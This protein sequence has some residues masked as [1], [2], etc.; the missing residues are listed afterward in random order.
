MSGADL[1]ADET[2][3][4]VGT[5]GGL[6][7][8]A[9]AGRPGPPGW[10]PDADDA[11]VA[12]DDRHLLDYFTA[13]VLPAITPRQRE[14]LVRAAPLERLSGCA[15]RRR[16]AGH[17]LGRR[18]W[19][20]SIGPTCSWSRS[21][22]TTSGTGATICSATCC[23][24]NRASRRPTV[25][26]CSRRAADWFAE[27][28]RLDDAVRHLLRADDPNA[29]ADAVG[30]LGAVVL[31]ARSRRHLPAARRAAAPS[32]GRAAIWRSRWPTRRDQ[33]ATRP[34][35][36]LARLC[37][38]GLARTPWC[39]AG[40][41][42]RAAVLMLRAVIG[43]PDKESAGRSSCAA[44]R[45]SWRPTPAAGAADRARRHWAAR[46]PGTAGSP[47]RPSIL[48]GLWRHRD[49]FAWSPGV[50]LQIGGN[51]GL[52]PA[53]A[54]PGRRSRAP[55]AGGAAARRRGGTRTGARR[56]GRWWRCCDS[57]RVDTAICRGDAGRRASGAEPGSPARRARGS[58]RRRTCW[59]W[60]TSP[61]PNSAAV[62]GW[63]PAPR[64]PGPGRTS[65][66]SR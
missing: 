6:G 20:P 57:S 42:P 8:R 39:G 44:R 4:G 63:P 32:D 59:R 55:S 62:T 47:R 26:R 2:D 49:N 29:A 21:T 33:R 22:T 65:T 25:A 15:V 19:P 66:T 24:G 12:G 51:L 45:S 38:A 56:P 30:V 9:A 46:W 31:R 53:R 41:N 50:T 60:C 37:D 10:P 52:E 27:Q 16:A 17:R 48:A 61:T 64:W 23:C 5:H 1:D 43:T 13:E 28:D 11:A 34:G 14:L 35:A 58:C 36:A 3:G 18:C 40:S 7:G 54:G